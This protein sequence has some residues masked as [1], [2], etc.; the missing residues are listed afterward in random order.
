MREKKWLP[1]FVAS[2]RMGKKE[3]TSSMRTYQPKTHSHRLG[4]VDRMRCSGSSKKRSLR[5]LSWR[6]RYGSVFASTQVVVGFSGFP[7][8]QNVRVVRNPVDPCLK[9]A[10][11]SRP[12]I[13]LHN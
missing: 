3:A 4:K 2:A 8:N 13:A 9:D 11:D 6:H 12:A 5:F 7:C 1:S 10:I